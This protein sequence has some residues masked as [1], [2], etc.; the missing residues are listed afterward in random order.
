[1]DTEPADVAC[2]RN[3]RPDSMRAIDTLPIRP[4]LRARLHTNGYHTVKDLAIGYHEGHITTRMGVSE[5]ELLQIQ[6]YLR[7]LEQKVRIKWWYNALEMLQHEEEPNHRITTGI[8]QLDSLLGGG[9]IPCGQLVEI[10]G[11]PGIGKTQLGTIRMQLAVNVQLPRALSGVAGEAVYID[12]EGSFR[13]ERVHKLAEYAARRANEQ[14]KFDAMRVPDVLHRIHY[15]R[16]HTHLELIALIHTLEEFVRSRT[17][18]RLIVIDSIAFPFRQSFENMSQRI[19]LLT[20]IARSLLSM[21]RQYQLGV[22][23]INQMTTQ[24][25][26]AQ[27]T[28]TL[29]P[30]LGDSWGH[31]PNIRLTLFWRQ[32]IRYALLFKSPL[33]A[34]ALAAFTITSNGLVDLDVNTI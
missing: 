8:H 31:M 6:E 3:Q 24:L 22:L 7:S 18:I 28:S 13:P 17:K 32:N 4:T 11:E 14:L 25:N 15:F 1:M 9:G 33:L 29:V 16:V 21:A 23:M 5:N 34:D 20:N 10:C 19:R 27:G 12:T 26:H 2:R 30:A